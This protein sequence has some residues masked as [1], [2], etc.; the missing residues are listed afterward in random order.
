MF[1]LSQ[2]GSKPEQLL[3]LGCDTLVAVATSVFPEK[4]LKPENSD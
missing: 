2:A 1:R 4:I 3:G